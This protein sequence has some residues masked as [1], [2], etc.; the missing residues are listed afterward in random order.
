[1]EHGKGGSLKEGLSSQ[2]ALGQKQ[3]RAAG[4]G[5]RPVKGSGTTTK[6]ST[7]DK[8]KGSKGMDY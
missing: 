4:R 5:E 3:T 7:G 8:S 1:M 2:S 6:A